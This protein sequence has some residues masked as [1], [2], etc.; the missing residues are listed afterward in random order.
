MEPLS[1]DDRYQEDFLVEGRLAF[2]LKGKVKGKYL[3]TAQM[4]TQEE[5]LGDLF[6][7]IHRKDP[8]SVFR[9]LDPDRY[10]PVY[11]DDSTTYSDTDT[12]GRMYV[13]VDWDKSEALWGNYHTG[14][15]GNEFGQYNRS[16]YGAKFHNRSLDTT[17]LG[18]A[19]RDAT[20]FVSEAQTSLG[21]S[22]F[23]GTGGSL[24]YLRHQDILPGSEKAHVEIRDR[25]SNRV[26]QNLTLVRG[27]DYE[28][29]ELQG[30]LIL[31]KPLAQVT[32]QFAPSLIKDQPLDGNDVI[33]LVDYEYVP[34]AF[35][36]DQ[37][38]V[39]GRGKQ[40]INDKVAV[41]V[42]A[43]DE[44]R[45]GEDYQMLGAD[46]TLQAGRGTYLKAEIARTE[47]TQAPVF[48][49]DNGG[50]TFA[51]TNPINQ[52]DREGDA[53]ALEGRI[54]FREQG[55]TQT[56]WT[57][58]TWWRQSDAGFSAARRDTGTE[59]TEYGA[60][61]TGEVNDR[62]RLS[63]RLTVVDRAGQ[64]EDQRVA[65]QGDYRLTDKGTVSA[66][67]RRQQTE[68][69]AAGTSLENTLAALRYTHRLSQSLE[70]HAT[71]Q[72]SVSSDAGVADNNLGTVGARWRVTDRTNVA[73]DYSNGDRGDAA[74]LSLDHRINS[75]HRVFGTYTMST[76][77]T[78]RDDRERQFTL[79]NRSRISNQTTVFTESQFSRGRRESG[80][81]HAFGLNFI[82]RAGWDLGLS[83]QHGELDALS[84]PV[85]R[86]AATLTGRF[87]NPSVEWNSKIE[88]RDDAGAEE[89]EQILT[90]N[91][92]SWRMSESLRMLMRFNLSDTNDLVDRSRDARFVEGGLGIA[93]RPV[94]NDRLNLLGRYTYLYDLPSIGQAQPA[95]D[96]RSHVLSVEGIYRLTPR[97]EVGAK[98]AQRGGKLRIDRDNGQWFRSTTN[99]YAL[100][101]R[102]HLIKRWD[103][104]LE[105]RWL[106]VEENAAVRSG[107]LA[108]ID[109]HFGDHF[110]VGVGYNFTDFSDD[111]TNLDYDH[112]GWFLNL[113]GKY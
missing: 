12:Q 110:K 77:R 19:K 52:A 36:S 45:G 3:V 42:T 31:A 59:L 103:G 97:W 89:R 22:E 100:R 87:R 2:Y 109:R 41:G 91:R 6:S 78:D 21:H 23:L 44:N 30:R 48:Y 66:E 108:A 68:N 96:Q 71:G 61:V 94:N 82:P 75:D 70:V 40:W 104:V 88:Y 69:V 80:V 95:T 25:D 16:L 57:A 15:T 10:Y 64:S 8:R 101:G 47:A 67:V 28:I 29:D 27:T 84:G 60:E 90:S 9:R 85:Q 93:Y 113:V 62:L 7:N 102:Y 50:L 43:V 32:Q 24:Y 51:T 58:A 112:K 107:L 111:L 106:E 17:E 20:V 81:T 55:L 54:N 53:L 49:S 56:D 39:G 92:A 98:L 1:G 26:V 5:E 18:E 65:V 63:A 35:Q 14:V 33:L 105:Y 34:D 74:T 83:L 38:T 46:V 79:G 72:F 4:D 76:D 37:M 99:F 73:A 11:G 86:D 13:R